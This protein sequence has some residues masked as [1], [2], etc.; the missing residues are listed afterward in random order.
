MIIK[1]DNFEENREA[2]LFAMHLLVPDD[3]LRKAIKGNNI[4]DIL[5]NEKAVRKLADRYKVTPGVIAA[6]LGQ[7]MEKEVPDLRQ[8]ESSSGSVGQ[9]E[10]RKKILSRE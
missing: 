10:E 1:Q 9:V 2:D 6:R 5:H 8:D 3:L 4:V 7:F